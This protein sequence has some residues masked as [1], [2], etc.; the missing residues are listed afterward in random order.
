M[1]TVLAVGLLWG[2]FLLV[3]LLVFAL[4]PGSKASPL[5]TLAVVVNCL[6]VFPAC[7]V[8]FWHRRAA[9][10]WLILNGLFIAAT[11]VRFT[12]HSHQYDWGMILGVLLSMVTLYR[13]HRKTCPFP[14]GAPVSL[15][16]LCRGLNRRRTHQG[17]PQS[18]LLGRSPADRPRMGSR[19]YVPGKDRDQP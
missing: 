2:A 13:R 11:T 12:L 19:G 16:P 4:T 8:A 15:A 10:V 17:V 3:Q 1:R 6:S 18:D 7:I 5:D 9:C 14:V